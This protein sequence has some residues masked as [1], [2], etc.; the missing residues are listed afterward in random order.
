MKENIKKVVVYGLSALTDGHAALYSGLQELKFAKCTIIQE[1][2][3]RTSK[4]LFNLELVEVNNNFF[5]KLFKL[6]KAF[7]D[8]DFVEVYLHKYGYRKEF[9]ELLVLLMLSVLRKRIVLNFTGRDIREWDEHT[10]FKRKI[11]KAF[12]K[13]SVFYTLKESYMHADIKNK[14]IG[15]IDKHVFIHNGVHNNF[16]K[17]ERII[18]KDKVVILYNNRIKEHR[19]IPYLLDVMRDVLEVRNEA[20]FVL[21]GIKNDAEMNELKSHLA[22]WDNDSQSKVLLLK[23]NDYREMIY[24]Q[25]DIFVMPADVVWLNNSILESMR[26]GVVPILPDVSWA[27]RI[28]PANTNENLIYK[29][30]NIKDFKNKLLELIDNEDLRVELSNKAKSHVELFLSSRKRALLHK[31]AYMAFV[32]N[33]DEGLKL[34]KFCDDYKILPLYD[35]EKVME[36]HV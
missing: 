33:N 34:L 30:L 11:I 8:A 20:F 24:S 26:Y 6:Y 17:Y 19:N 2:F 22:K 9:N 32:D 27:D 3:D 4:Q 29:H 14:K 5:I 16:K 10:W 36:D 7:I 13:K 21:S 25:S 18:S 31:L 1:S 12:I 28:I 23:I 35:V 15:D